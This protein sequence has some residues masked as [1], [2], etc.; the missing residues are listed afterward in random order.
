MQ[1]LL[2]RASNSRNNAI[3]KR[4]PPFSDKG[5]MYR[6]APFGILVLLFA[7]M[8][9]SPAVRAETETPAIST[10]T[11]QTDCQAEPK[12]TKEPDELFASINVRG[13]AKNLAGQ[14]VVGATIFLVSTIAINQRLG[15]TKTDADG[16]Y[17]FLDVKLPVKQFKEI[18]A[19]AFQVYGEANGYG[20]A[21]HGRRSYSSEPRPKSEPLEEEESGFYADDPIVMDLT[22]RDRAALMG[23]VTDEKGLPLPNVKI[24]LSA[25]DYLD[26]KGHEIHQNYREFWAI[27]STGYSTTLTGADGR[28]EFSGMPS[29][30]VAYVIVEASG[31]ADQTFFAAV[32]DK[33]ITENKYQSNA[34]EMFSN[35]RRIRTP[36]WETRKVRAGPLNIRLEATE[37]YVINVVNDIDGTLVQGVQVRA[38]SGDGQTGTHASDTT[39]ETGRAIL[40]L[41][42]GTF[43]LSA[44]PPRDTDFVAAYSQFEARGDLIKEPVEMRL[45]LGC[46]LI[47]EVVNGANGSPV[48]GLSI[49]CDVDG[50]PGRKVTVQSTTT[51]AD[52]PVTNAKGELRAVVLPGSRNY[53]ISSARLP[54][55]LRA[56]P[57]SIKQLIKCESGKT[58]RVRFEVR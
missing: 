4:T 1:I 13:R 17:E 27:Q 25:L 9:S 36:I 51:W 38:N 31:F 37:R 10:I 18:R 49:Y 23:V 44:A 41:P 34:S 39:N 47:L 26:T 16:Q 11:S 46:V 54:G 15:E 19:G 21:W 45:K 24:R 43:R 5:H 55:G 40:A 8:V 22:F 52:N 53:E 30:T 33:P 6:M 50:K 7:A 42:R 56:D 57:K 28:F 32:T 3:R 14:P 58:I 35:G 12:A 2:Q 48:P 20:F 29:Q